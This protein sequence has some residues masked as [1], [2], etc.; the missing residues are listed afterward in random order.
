MHR[1]DSRWINWMAR[2]LENELENCHPK[3]PDERRYIESEIER[4]WKFKGT[5]S[6]NMPWSVYEWVCYIS[7][8]ATA[9]AEVG[10]S[11]HT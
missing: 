1:W 9:A 2:S 5:Y 8:L 11:I 4:L 7:V 3:W 10:S 6:R